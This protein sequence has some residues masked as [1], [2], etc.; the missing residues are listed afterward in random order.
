MMD[1]RARPLGGCYRTRDNVIVK[2]TREYTGIAP[3][4]TYQMYLIYLSKKK[5]NARKRTYTY[6]VHI[7]EIILK[8]F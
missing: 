2:Y 5:E 6:M 7:G 4:T 8:A 1:W 3:C